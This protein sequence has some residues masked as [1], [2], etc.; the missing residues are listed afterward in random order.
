M[1]CMLLK[2]IHKYTTKKKE[3]KK[4]RQKDLN[5]IPVV[6]ELLDTLC[7]VTLWDDWARISGIQTSLHTSS[8]VTIKT[9]LTG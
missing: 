7:D 6:D 9:R 5:S 8:L 2:M 3:R 1:L 4:E